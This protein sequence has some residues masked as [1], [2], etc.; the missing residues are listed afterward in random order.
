MKTLAPILTAA[1]LLAACSSASD[2]PKAASVGGGPGPAGSVSSTSTPAGE[3]ACE[4]D[5]DCAVVETECC[6]HCNGGKVEA[7]RREFADAHKKAGCERTMCTERG[8]GAAS[9]VC[10]DHACAVVIAPLSAPE[11]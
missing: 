2:E 1:L 5:A 9:A 11:S 10:R 7:Y 6:D 8:C 3:A 4:A